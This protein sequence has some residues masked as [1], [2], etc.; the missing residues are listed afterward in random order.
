MLN[1]LNSLLSVSPHSIE[2]CVHQLQ[3][4]FLTLSPLLSAQR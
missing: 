1:W 4:T 3:Q 2:S